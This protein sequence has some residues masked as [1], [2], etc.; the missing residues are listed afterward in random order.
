MRR[1][2]DE[3]SRGGSALGGSGVGLA[4][5]RLLLP[6]YWSLWFP[7]RHL[8][9]CRGLPAG[10]GEGAGRGPRRPKAP[11]SY[12]DAPVQSP[13]PPTTARRPF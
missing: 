4:L 12:P 6:S 13:A 10:H 11:T 8:W 5:P 3:E 7:S 9:R 2:T 1:G